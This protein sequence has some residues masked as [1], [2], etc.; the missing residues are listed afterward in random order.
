VR[1]SPALD[2]IKN[3]ELYR[4]TMSDERG[5]LSSGYTPRRGNVRRTLPIV[6]QG[7]LLSDVAQM[8]RQR[9]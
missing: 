6:Q 4:Y 7:L 8:A 5:F 1:G 2:T 9:Q 3:L